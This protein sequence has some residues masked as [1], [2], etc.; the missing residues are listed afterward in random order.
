MDA[1]WEEF[2]RVRFADVSINQ[3]LRRA[4]IPC[5]SFYQYFSGKE[6]LFIYLLNIVQKHVQTLYQGHWSRAAAICFGPSWSALTV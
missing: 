3:I 1:A 6:E 5:G 2:T 4:G